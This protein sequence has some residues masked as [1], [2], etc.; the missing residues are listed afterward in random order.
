MKNQCST[1]S[2][3]SKSTF[4]AMLGPVAYKKDQFFDEFG[5][6]TNAEKLYNKYLNKE[7]PFNPYRDDEYYSNT[8]TRRFFEKI[9]YPWSIVSFDPKTRLAC[10]QIDDPKGIKNVSVTL[11]NLI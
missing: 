5:L 4:L 1:Y 6:P 8:K 7:Y 9:P 3:L 11:P 2:R 10:I